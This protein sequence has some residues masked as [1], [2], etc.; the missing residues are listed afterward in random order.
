MPAGES[1]SSRKKKR[2]PRW[3]KLGTKEGKKKRERRASAGDVTMS[4]HRGVSRV[5]SRMGVGDAVEAEGRKRVSMGS[6]RPYQ[7]KRLGGARARL[8]I[9]G[10]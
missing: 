5:S 8:G 9:G 7:E 2:R 3:K 6:S 4:G 1:E 10:Q